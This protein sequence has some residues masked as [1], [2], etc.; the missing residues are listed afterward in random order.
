MFKRYP[1]FPNRD[2]LE[3]RIVCE[4]LVGSLAKGLALTTCLEVLE[5]RLSSGR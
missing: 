5:I 1:A 2:G 3:L 4:L